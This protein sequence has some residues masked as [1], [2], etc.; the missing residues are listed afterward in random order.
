MKISEKVHFAD[1]DRTMIVQSTYDNNPALARAEALR[2]QTGGIAGESRLV[3]TLPMHIIKEWITEPGL[4]WSD[5]EAIDDLRR[6]KL[7][8]GEFD[9]FRVWSGKF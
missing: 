7:L 4:E 3:G 6:K 1:N 9:K 2:E 8:S 5:S